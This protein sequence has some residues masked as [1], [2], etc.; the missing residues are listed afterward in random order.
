[1]GYPVYEHFKFQ[2]GQFVMSAF[3]GLQAARIRK[4][5]DN[6]G[7][8][9]YHLPPRV[10]FQIVERK[11][12]E[13]PGGVQLFYAVRANDQNDGMTVDVSWVHEIELAAIP[14]EE[15]AGETTGGGG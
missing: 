13:C 8:R 9:P 1:M 6:G 10:Y 4:T 5:L 14:A 15:Q 7:Q 12:Q 11:Y 3:D 2:I